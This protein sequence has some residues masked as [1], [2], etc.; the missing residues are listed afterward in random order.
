MGKKR[1]HNQGPDKNA[2][3]DATLNSKVPPLVEEMLAHLENGRIV[4]A[5]K[6]FLTGQAGGIFPP[7]HN[8][9]E[10][11]VQTI[12]KKATSRII[13]AFAHYPCPFCKKGRSKCPD[14]K[15]HGHINYDMIC[16]RCL[17]IGVVR[18]DFCDG[19]GWMAMRDVPEGLRITVFTMRAQT[20]LKRLKLIFAEPLPPP[21]KNKPLI[22]LKKFARLL[23]KVDRYMGVLEN[24]LLMAGKLCVMLYLKTDDN[25]KD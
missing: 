8:L 19:S 15:G 14:C 22:A 21:S 16:D 11:L 10:K 9:P 3:A 4:E 5:A 18:C 17:G 23:V 1:N 13:I 20:A 24:V 6:L 12:G 2:Q 25:E 7:D